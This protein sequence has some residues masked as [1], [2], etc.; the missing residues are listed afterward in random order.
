MKRINYKEMLT[1]L[2]GP[3][4][5]MIHQSHS[6]DFPKAHQPNSL[7]KTLCSR[8]TFFCLFVCFLSF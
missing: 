2:V 3:N 5:H 4:L 1:A 7:N 8:I 6:S